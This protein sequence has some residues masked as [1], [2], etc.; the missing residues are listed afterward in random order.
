[1]A[2]P[3][4]TLSSTSIPASWTNPYQRSRTNPLID[5]EIG[6]IGIQQPGQGL[7]IRVWKGYYEA[8]KIYVTPEE[9]GPI[10]EVLS[11]ANVTEIGLTFDQNMRPTVC[12]VDDDGLK[13]FWYDSTIPGMTTT[14]FPNAIS[15]MVRLDDKRTLQSA[16]SDILFVYLE[17]GKLK[18]RQQRERFQVEYIIKDTSA[19]RVIQVGMNTKWRIQFQLAGELPECVAIDD[20]VS[21]ACVLADMATRTNVPYNAVDLLDATMIGYRIDTQQSARSW[22]EPLMT[23]YYFDAFESDG[24]VV[25]RT[26]YREPVSTYTDEDLAATANA[27]EKIDKT[28]I[29]RTQESE[30]PRVINIGYK[31]IDADH[32][33]GIQT[34]TRLATDAVS[35]SIINLPIVMNKDEAKRKAEE[36]LR[37]IWLNRESI[38]F[39]VPAT[40]IHLRPTDKVIL[41]VDGVQNLVRITG[42]SYQISGVIKCDGV[43]ESMEGLTEYSSYIDWR[44]DSS[45]T[46]GGTIVSEA[47]SLPGPIQGYWMDIPLLR[48]THDQQ[49]VYVATGTASGFRGGFV[50]M[51]FDDGI[52]W[53]FV[54]R[55]TRAVVGVTQTALANPIHEGIVDWGRTVRVSL[56]NTNDQLYSISPVTALQRTQNA[57]LI[58]NEVIVFEQ[59]TLVSPGVYDLTGLQRGLRG[60]DVY[61][62]HATA[63]EPFILLDTNVIRINIADSRIGSSFLIKYLAYGQALEDV[64][65]TTVTY[66]AVALEPYSV[67]HLTATSLGGGSY[68]I[69]WIRRTRIDGEWRDLVDAALSEAIEEYVVQ[70][71]RSNSQISTVTVTTNTA[72]VSALA[73]DV[74][75]VYQRSAVV[76]TGFIKEVNIT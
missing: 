29:T 74:V 32:E 8:G 52:T 10:T 4:T 59:A 21:V 46:A 70:V 37:K 2:L 51:S 45:G 66:D 47:P 56:L 7:N 76:G 67:A 68:K 18:F 6:G 50:Y 44:S 34:A 1:M 35:E 60:T 27:N 38:S 55:T 49:G 31:D 15:G 57:A 58:G 62:N 40:Q 33:P 42:I 71:W 14:T 36:L 22:I 16:T 43:V 69:D 72:T 73:G 28:S 23:A 48:D 41:D 12:Y 65:P 11:A 25:F 63:G 13:L 26:R 53:S 61:M 5:Y 17:D 3:S 39:N 75:K 30:L 20:R 64:A 9:G 24:T 54:E 19:E